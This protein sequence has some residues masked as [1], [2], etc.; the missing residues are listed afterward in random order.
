MSSPHWT[1]STG[2]ACL[3][4]CPKPCFSGVKTSCFSVGASSSNPPVYSWAASI[5]ELVFSPWIVLE[6]V[7]FAARLLH[8]CG[9]CAAVVV[10]CAVQTVTVPEWFGNL[11]ALFLGTVTLERQNPSQPKQPM[12]IK[13]QWESTDWGNTCGKSG[14]SSATWWF[15]VRPGHPG[16]WH[17]TN[18]A[19]TWLC[20][21]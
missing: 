8:V 2:L 21:F 11:A 12:E 13:D 9:F 10:C 19:E 18:T 1:L 20:D 17:S 3:W 6:V 7:S 14:L 4:G 15:C 5:P 16:V